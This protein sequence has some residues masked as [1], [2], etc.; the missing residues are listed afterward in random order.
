MASSLKNFIHSL[1][2]KSLPRILQI[3]SGFYEEGSVHEKFDHE[4]CLS[5]GDVIKIVGLKVKK[6]IASNCESDDSPCSTTVELPLDFP[7]LC[8]VV[9][10]KTP[11]TSTEEIVRKVLIG[12][13]QLQHPCFYCSEDLN[14]GEV[15]IKQGEKITF[16][17]VEEE[18]GIIIVNAG[19]TRNDQSCAIALPLSQEGAFYEWQDDYTYT[20]KEIAEWK[21]AKGR[22]RS[23][24]FTNVCTTED[25]F[26][27]D[28]EHC[29]TLFP[30][31]EVQAVMKFQKEIVHFHSDLD[32]EVKDVTGSYNI[33]S[34]LQPLSMEDILK[35][36]S[37]EFPMVVAVIEESTGN[38]QSYNLL[39]PGREVIIYKKHRATRILASEIKKAFYKRHFLIP[40][41]YKG[42]FKRQ[43]REFP[44]AYDLEIAR[45]V[46]EQL[47]VT[48]TKAFVSP[49]ENLCSVSIGDQFLISQRNTSEVVDQGKK[50]VE[51]VLVCEKI[52]L[53]DKTY[54][55]VLLP[56]CMEGGFVEIVH[57]H[58]QYEISELCKD[59][60]LPFNVKVSKRDLSIQDDILVDI[61]CLQ[62]EEEITDAFLL[63][64]SLNNPTEVWEV[65]VH[66]LNMSFQLVRKHVEEIVCFPTKSIVEEITEEQYCMM[67]RYESQATTPPPRP[68][69]THK[70]EESKTTFLTVPVQSACGSP[71]TMKNPYVDVAKKHLSNQVAAVLGSQLS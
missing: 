5:T 44:T 50:E 2:P 21:I 31:Y 64:S 35:K 22:K 62:L 66:R 24:I 8:N 1:N 14:I 61:P 59:F 54:K 49:Q 45:S 18:N 7:G 32:V 6:L 69:K 15:T 19:V 51:N 36:T 71:K 13:T 39:C 29:V 56:M 30:V 23:V 10:D 60:H 40:A 34:F 53:L 16:R 43:P 4:C 41:N 9:T 46:K 67:R 42:K 26:P 55:N 58:N 25:L 63:I 12:S 11:F 52:L 57:D 3:Q 27:L 20:L 17:S 28:F 68:P 47:H 48:A 70:A 38:K 37:N 33:N 65:P